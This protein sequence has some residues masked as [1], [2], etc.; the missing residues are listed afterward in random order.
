MLLLNQEFLSGYTTMCILMLG[1]LVNAAIGP[2]GITLSMTGH[3]K[4][5]LRCLAYAAGAN[6][7]LLL[8]LEL[9]SQ[10]NIESV[11]VISSAILIFWNLGVAIK[12]YQYFGILPL[13]L[14]FSKN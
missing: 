14:S 11:A 1:Q 9:T 8:L 6:L 3:E 7:I 5:V 12:G 4:D 2:I 13:G 10:V